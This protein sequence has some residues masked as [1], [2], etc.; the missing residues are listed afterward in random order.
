MTVDDSSFRRVHRGD[1]GKRRLETLGRG[2]VDNLDAFDA[3]ELRLLI[4]RFQSLD[5]ARVGGDDKLAAFAV[6]HA[7]RG[8]EFVE[9]AP[10]ARAVIGAPRTGRIIKAGVDDLA[11]A[12]GHPSADAGGGFRHHHV[13]AG[14]RRRAGNR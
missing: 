7:V 14:V 4:Y 12:R 11:V 8:A 6:R 9:H 3:V 1:A 13:V 10:A 5:F 2:D